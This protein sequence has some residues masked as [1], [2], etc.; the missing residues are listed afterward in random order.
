MAGKKKS[1]SNSK[2]GL[3]VLVSVVII[4]IA[5][6]WFLGGKPYIEIGAEGVTLVQTEEPLAVQIYDVLTGQEEQNIVEPE[7]SSADPETATAVPELVEG[8]RTNISPA[9]LDHLQN[10][11]LFF[12]NPSDA[13]DDTTL[14][15]NYLMVKPQYTLSYNAQTF[16]PNWVAWHLDTENMGSADRMDDFRPDPQLPQG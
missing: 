3:T 8:P 11:P 7:D 14:E 10:D 13:I 12:G 1:K 5:A 4:L 2:K 9:D 15:T 16:C 6:A